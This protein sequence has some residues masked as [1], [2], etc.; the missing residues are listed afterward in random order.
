MPMDTVSPVKFIDTFGMATCDETAL[1]L[2]RGLDDDLSGTEAA[3]L[4]AHVAA[5]DACRRTMG[6]MAA[7]DLALRRLNQAYGTATLDAGFAVELTG[8]L[9][10]WPADSGVAQLRQFGRRTSQDAALRDKLQAAGDHAGFVRL[11]VQLGR[12]NGYSFSAEDVAAHLGS[13]AANDDELSDEQLDRVAAGA[14]FD[15]RALLDLLNGLG[16]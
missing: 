10:A 9:A 11:C 7:L 15:G 8:K 3:V 6:E 12:E 5:C 16:E 14:G 2:S 4:Y 13:V 1:L